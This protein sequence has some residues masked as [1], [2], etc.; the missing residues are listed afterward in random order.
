MHWT[1]REWD[2]DGD[3]DNTLQYEMIIVMKL[4]LNRITSMATQ[5]HVTFGLLGENFSSL[6]PH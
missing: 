2:S 4:E 6:G 3:G 1:F 5:Q